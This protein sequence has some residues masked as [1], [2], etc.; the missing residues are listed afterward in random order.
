MD[1][2]TP[3]KLM[4]EFI[5]PLSLLTTELM[6]EAQK[7]EDAYAKKRITVAW[8]PLNER[9]AMKAVAVLKKFLRDEVKSK[10]EDAEEGT[11]RY[12]EAELKFRKQS[13]VDKKA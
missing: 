3:E 10:R 1:R 5:V 8:L 7:L 9:G 2:F 12:R 6:G 4:T 13:K 11:L